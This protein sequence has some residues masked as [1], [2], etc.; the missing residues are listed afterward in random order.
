MRNLG[1]IR[2]VKANKA[3][4]LL[5][6]LASIDFPSSDKKHISEFSK[7]IP[8]RSVGIITHRHFVKKKLLE[9]LATEIQLKIKNRIIPKTKNGERLNPLQ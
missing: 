2:F 3:A 8:F 4:T 9:K 6:Y 1:L 7:P 5:P